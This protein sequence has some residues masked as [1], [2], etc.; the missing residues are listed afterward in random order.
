MART[1]S[2][3]TAVDNIVAVTGIPFL[4]LLHH[5]QTL[6]EHERALVA[7]APAELPRAVVVAA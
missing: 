5:M 2:T 7:G 3:E 1:P 6:V 4:R